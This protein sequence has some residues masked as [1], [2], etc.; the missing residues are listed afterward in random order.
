MIPAD[1]YEDSINNPFFYMLVGSMV[2]S[3]CFVFWWDMVMDW[4]LFDKSAGEY[5]FLR[6]ELVYSSPVSLHFAEF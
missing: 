5:K 2:F 1:Q 4:G 6:E 3:S